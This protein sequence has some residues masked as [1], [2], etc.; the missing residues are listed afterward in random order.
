MLDDIW[1]YIEGIYDFLVGLPDYL[2]GLILDV[3]GYCVDLS[4]TVLALFLEYTLKLIAIP[5][6][7]LTSAAN[8]AGLPPLGVYLLTA[9]GLGQIMAMIATAYTIRFAINLIPSWATRA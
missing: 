9:L 3:L 8:M 6:S 4:F 7:L 5:S 1:K 2:L